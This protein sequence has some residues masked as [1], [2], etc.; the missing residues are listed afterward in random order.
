MQKPNKQTT[1]RREGIK[2]LIKAP[3]DKEQHTS[4]PFY[5]PSLK[6]FSA[7]KLHW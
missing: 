6:T 3:T 2:I 5:E 7:E 1:V 4:S